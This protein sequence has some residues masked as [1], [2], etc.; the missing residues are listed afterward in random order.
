M[1]AER[2]LALC[3]ELTLGN[4]TSSRSA[5]ANPAGTVRVGE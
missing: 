4:G 1:G 3:K 2:N 5:D